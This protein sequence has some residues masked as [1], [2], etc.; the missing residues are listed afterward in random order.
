MNILWRK[1]AINSLIELDRWRSTLELASISL[2]LKGKIDLYFKQQNLEVYIPGRN[3]IVKGLPVE[4]IM[5]LIPIGRSDPY[6][7]YYRL[8]D[9]D[10]EII[11]V[12]H[13][14]KRKYINSIYLFNKSFIK[15]TP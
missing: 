11:L 15:L 5:V 14:I 8:I 9:N 1:S 2:I 6:K 3:V 12:R 13:P 7:I 10:I 4:L